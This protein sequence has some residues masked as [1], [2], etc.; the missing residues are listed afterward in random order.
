M[1]SI[2]NS[3]QVETAIK[4]FEKGFI[5]VSWLFLCFKFT[6]FLKKLFVSFEVI[7]LFYQPNQNVDTYGRVKRFRL[8]NFKGK[9]NKKNELF[10]WKLNWSQRIFWLYFQETK[11]N[12]DGIKKN[13]NLTFFNI[14]QI[15]K[16]V[17]FTNIIC[18]LIFILKIFLFLF[19][20]Y[21]VFSEYFWLFSIFLYDVLT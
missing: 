14:W 1:T 20:Y 6:W 16:K 9:N 12:T 5:V 10:P 21:W 19:F 3:V 8:R 11:K 15:L 17:K 7:F 4:E 13:V 18:M 2:V